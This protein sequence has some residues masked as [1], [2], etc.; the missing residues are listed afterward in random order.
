MS[1]EEKKAIAAKAEIAEYNEAFLR[2]EETH[3]PQWA[4]NFLL[5]YAALLATKQLIE[6]MMQ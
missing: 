1:E 6:R 5:Q 4:D 2:G 3:Y